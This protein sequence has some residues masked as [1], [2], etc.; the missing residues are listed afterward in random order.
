M[1]F[2]KR[3]L[4]SKPV[5]SKKEE[6]K[7]PDIQFGRYT[8][9]N[10]TEKQYQAWDKTVAFYKEKK[11]LDS[12]F[13]FFNYLRDEKEDNVKFSK[14]FDK[15]SFEIIQ[16][17]KIVKGYATEK[18][19]EAE[20]D[21]AKFNEKPHVAVMRKLLS[22][23]YNLFFS[24]FAINKNVYT[25][26]LSL[27]VSDC[28]PTALYFALKEIANKSDM[29]DDVL[30]DEFS[31]LEPVNVSHI[32]ELPDT[33]KDIKYNRLQSLINQTIKRA[34]ELNSDSFSGAISFLLL[35]L[36]FKLYYLLAPE[37]VLLDEI[38][39]IQ[40]I[41]F[42]RNEMPTQERNHL[43]IKE[44]KKIINKSK[45]ENLKSL[46]RTKATFAV[47]GA[48]NYKTIADFIKDEIKKVEWYRK[49]NYHDIV[50]A[51]CDYIVSYIEFSWGLD[52]ILYELFDIYWRLTNYEFYQ[53]L[54]YLTTYFD[55]ET[56]KIDQV[57]IESKIYSIQTTYKS[58]YPNLSIKTSNLKYTSLSEFSIS[59]VN[60]MQYLN[61]N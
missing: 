34:E 13:E 21:I 2:F 19:I 7:E 56:K 58:R 42:S 4:S 20:A 22:V 43:M 41:F 15:I 18:G 5:E 37:G 8:D 53:K 60:E 6:I 52:S 48:A 30:T 17:S 9:K 44:Y 55:T 16:G 14:E 23:N 24:K 61:L 49:N 35:S 40:G 59:F 39:Y 25:L 32:L 50:Q 26:K 46:Y 28:E 27:P 57:K 51:I 38:R 31:F 12:F 45:E 33:E 47:V 36:T 3:I 29:Y 10:K 1:G 54:G 11:Y